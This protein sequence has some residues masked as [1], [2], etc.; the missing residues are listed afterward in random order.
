MKG[1]R[2]WRRDA[3]LPARAGDLSLAPLTTGE[4]AELARGELLLPGAPDVETVEWTYAR[5]KP[6]TSLSAG[7]ELVLADGDRRLLHVKRYA[8]GKA[9]HLV[10][11]ET[12]GLRGG[13]SDARLRAGLSRPDE[14]LVLTVFP[15]DRVL[16]GLSRVL[17]LRRMARFATAEGFLQ[18]ARMRAHRSSLMLLRYRP[19]ARA[20]FCLEAGAKLDD[21]T[22]RTTRVAVR[23][24]SPATAARVVAARRGLGSSAGV[25]SLLAAQPRTGILLEEWLEVET[26]S[27]FSFEHAREAGAALAALHSTSYPPASEPASDVTVGERAELVALFAWHPELAE[28]SRALE[29]VKPEGASVWCHGD[30]HPD[31]LGVDGRTGRMR[32]LDLDRLAPAAAATDLGSWLADQLAVQPGANLEQAAAPLLDGYAS[33]GGCVPTSCALAAA[34]AGELVA[35]AAACVRRLEVGAAAR[36]ARLL[37][38]ARRLQ[39][40]CRADRIGAR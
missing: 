13:W 25:P 3:G 21:G 12:A 20:V 39:Q 5:W 8:S 27:P 36:A 2:A 32:L 1:L 37:L 15:G 35:R 14:G 29:P 16:P 40:R 24:L 34:T 31:Q 4:V 9:R 23:V 6:G 30:F 22:H 26:F 18:G 7:Y 28:L 38:Q 10:G 33:A 11:R 17:D 19:E